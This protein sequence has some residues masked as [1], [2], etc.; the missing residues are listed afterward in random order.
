MKP[1]KQELKIWIDRT[2]KC[3]H[4]DCSMNCDGDDLF[5]FDPVCGTDGKTYPNSCYLSQAS[6]KQRQFIGDNIEGVENSE[7]SQAYEGECKGRKWYII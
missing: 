3:N 5:L 7:L 2:H 4:T 6:C 1:F